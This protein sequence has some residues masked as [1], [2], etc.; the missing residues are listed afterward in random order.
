MLLPAGV[1]AYRLV[2]GIVGLITYAFGLLVW[3]VGPW[4]VRLVGPRGCIQGQ[5]VMVSTDFFGGG[6]HLHPL[7]L[8]GLCPWWQ[9]GTT[10][11]AEEREKKA[12][13]S[14]D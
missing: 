4:G 12:A 14:I 6:V 10:A 5:D 7:G 13:A 9:A 2:L 8:T 1:D 11:M 3:E